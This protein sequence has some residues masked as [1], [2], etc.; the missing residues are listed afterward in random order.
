MT[1]TINGTAWSGQAGGYRHAGTLNNLTFEGWTGSTLTDFHQIA[2]GVSPNINAPGTYPV[3][4]SPTSISYVEPGKKH[5]DSY[6]RNPSGTLTINVLTATNVQGSFEVILEDDTGKTV[7][8]TN[9]KF[10]APL[11]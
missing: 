4:G 2:I 3:D 7:T 11:Q 1:A 6:H 5:S 8:M 10:N 9:G